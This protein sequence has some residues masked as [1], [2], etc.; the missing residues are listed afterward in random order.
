MF[1]DIQ[2]PILF[3]NFNRYIWQ[4]EN[5][6]QLTIQWSKTKQQINLSDRSYSVVVAAYEHHQTSL[7]CLGNIVL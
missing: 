3:D 6:L 1:D 7:T 5:T 4:R 2:K